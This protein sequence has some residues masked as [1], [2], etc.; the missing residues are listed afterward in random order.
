MKWRCWIKITDAKFWTKVLFSNGFYQIPNMRWVFLHSYFLG[1]LDVKSSFLTKT[2]C[3]VEGCYHKNANKG[4]QKEMNRLYF[5]ISYTASHEKEIM[6]SDETWVRYVNAG[7]NNIQWMRL[8]NPFKL[9][10]Q[11][12]SPYLNATGLL[13]VEFGTKITFKV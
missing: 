3:F 1:Y 2:D 6:T 12:K 5:K 13:I 7:R 11:E 10:Q 9:G 8:R 4:P